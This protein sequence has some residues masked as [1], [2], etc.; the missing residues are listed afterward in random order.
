MTSSPA[1][2]FYV[3]RYQRKAV[4]KGCGSDH[5]VGNVQWPTGKLPLPIECAQ[6]SAIIRVT[7]KMRS[8]NQ[9]GTIS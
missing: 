4:F 8:W 9:D 6:R 2:F 7:G 1:K 5:A 3:T